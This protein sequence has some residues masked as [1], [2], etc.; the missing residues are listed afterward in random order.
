MRVVHDGVDRI[1]GIYVRIQRH[2]EVVQAVQR[3]HNV[4]A[5]DVSSVMDIPVLAWVCS[6]SCKGFLVTQEKVTVS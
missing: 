3:V 2:A 5:G 4:K 6:V 1:L